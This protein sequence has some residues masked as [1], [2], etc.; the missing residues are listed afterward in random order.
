MGGILVA[1]QFHPLFGADINV[2]AYIQFQATPLQQFWPAVLLAVGIL[3]TYSVFSFNP[4]RDAKLPG[5]G[6]WTIRSDHE[7]GNLG[8][9][10]LSLKPTNPKEL[11]DF[12][13]KRSTMAVSP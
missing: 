9:D 5:K 4:P 10:P 2:P 11:K 13:R 8:F 12:R 3:E 7:P 1:E 6:P